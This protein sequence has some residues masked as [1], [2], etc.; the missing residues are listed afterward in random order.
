[1][2]N[3]I[4]RKER[5][6]TVTV[7]FDDERLKEAMVDFARAKAGAKGQLRHVE[8]AAQARQKGAP[9]FAGG[10]AVFD[11]MEI[12]E[13]DGDGERLVAPSDEVA[14]SGVKRETISLN[15]GDGRDVSCSIYLMYDGN[16]EL[17]LCIY[18][19]E[20]CLRVDSPYGTMVRPIGKDLEK[21]LR[22]EFADKVQQAD[23]RRREREKEE[24][25]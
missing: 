24:D 11:E 10:I 1:M 23:I 13:E 8:V 21:A 12:I 4:K 15:H 16:N 19:G 7:R 3:W 2:R 20:P 9:A 6:T 5:L 18:R 25:D 14:P 17:A 22:V